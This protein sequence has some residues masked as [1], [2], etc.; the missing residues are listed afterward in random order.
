[1][2]KYLLTIGV[3]LIIIIIA[4]ILFFTFKTNIN[5]SEALNIA[6]EYLGKTEKEFSYMKIERDLSDNTYEIKLNDNEYN[7]EIEIDTK[8]GNIIDFEK[9]P[10][11]NINNTN[12]NNNN[13]NNYITEQTAKEKVL[14]HANL[15]E[16]DVV[17]T[18]IKMEYDKNIMKYEVEFIYNYKEYEY[19]IDATSG[20]II[21]FKIDN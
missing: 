16:N 9:K 14:E 13:N 12:T 4:I 6:Y 18:K 7:Y 21:K 3:I 20:N 1:M 19:E 17:F 8:T 15:N 2:K 5:K 11:S 10:I